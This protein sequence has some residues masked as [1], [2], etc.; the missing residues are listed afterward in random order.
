MMIVKILAGVCS[1][2][3]VSASCAFA[4]AVINFHGQIDLVQE[5]FDVMLDFPGDFT[6]PAP[7]KL[8]NKRSSVAISGVKLS[9]KGYRLS[10]DIDHLRTPVCDLLSKIESSIEVV[11]RSAGK[12][13][14]MA[15]GEIWSR[16]SLVD[17]KP[18]HELIGQFEIKDSQLVVKSVSFGN[19]SCH[20]SLELVYPYKMDMK[21]FLH[22]VAMEDFLNFWSRN[23]GYK[24][25]GTVSGEIGV[26]GTWDRLG[27]TGR[28]ES[29]DG[30]VEQL[31]YNSIHLNAQGVYPRLSINPSTISKADGLSFTFSGPIDLSDQK[32]FKKQI[33]A[34][35][36]APLVSDS[37]S[38]RQ[39]TI[40]RLNQLNSGATEIKY[41]L[42]KEEQP[43]DASGML[44]VQRTMSF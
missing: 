17:Y 32:N 22:D 5:Q 20:G 15:R 37:A 43:E 36:L 13:A 34:L 4:N 10:L 31:A 44:G 21:V 40:K 24:S 33:G 16:D 41:L 3:L 11:P 1:F 25:S 26:A 28:L 6:G 8:E 12:S 35:V 27:L 30:Y 2:I 14:P 18:I 9:H 29:F 38:E 39:W 23:K 42:R 19:L 7:G